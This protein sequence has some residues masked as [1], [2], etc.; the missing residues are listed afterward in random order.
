MKKILVSSLVFSFLMLWGSSQPGYGQQ[1]QDLSQPVNSGEVKNRFIQDL[2]QSVSCQAADMGFDYT[3]R[4]VIGVLVAD[5]SNTSGEEIVLGNEIAAELRAALNKGKQFQ[6]YGKEH[7]ISQELKTVLAN[8]PKWS[9][10]SQRKFQQG[11][12]KKFKSYPVDLIITGQINKETAEKGE[13]LNIVVYLSPFIESITLVEG[14]TGKTD[15]RKELFVSPILPPQAI[16]RALTVI[17]VQVV[18]KGRLV[19]V[20]L[21]NL[22]KGKESVLEYKASQDT[23]SQKIAAL[24]FEK[25]WRLSSLKEV[26]CW[27]DDKELTAI[28]NWQGD[29]KQLYYNI[30][31]GFGADT[32]WFDDSVPDGAHSI[33][34]SLAQDPSKNRYKTF[35][36]SF[37][38]KGGQSN[39]LF[40]SFQSD[41]FGEPVLQVQHIIDPENLTLPF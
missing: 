10:T 15:F 21:L 9:G 8:D 32:I 4:P 31:S 29:K 1:I 17:K 12:L 34:F 39:Y 14:E 41:S 19:L 13:R 27:L 3:Q 11:L 16:D 30:L 5:F 35:S 33:F 36:K 6:V 18:P 20:S 40:F 25:P 23:T 7:P 28:Q 37:S 26:T 2:I 38:I 22:D 24:S